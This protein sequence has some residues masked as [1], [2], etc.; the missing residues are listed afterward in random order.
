METKA[1]RLASMLGEAQETRRQW[2]AFTE[3]TRRV[4]I[5]A[6]LELRRRH[7][8]MELEPLRSAEP[9][10]IIPAHPAAIREDVWVQLT[11]DGAEHLAGAEGQSA[12]A[13]AATDPHVTSAQREA[14]GQQALG[15]THGTV[16]DEIPEQVLR[17]RD[18]VRK[19]Q[20]IIDQHRETPEYAEHDSSEYLGAAWG[21]L[22]SRER[23]AI[24]QPPKPDIAPA[25]ELARQAAE[26]QAV[27][28]G[29]EHA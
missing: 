5:A 25:A 8:G 17:I 16:H 23:D 22:T 29:P 14:C 21:D 1:T 20:E 4:A 26:R 28:D 6:D 2:E 7:P 24:L 9:E 27:H 11:L 3:R 10:G 18:N 15:L 19:A 13:S 12:A